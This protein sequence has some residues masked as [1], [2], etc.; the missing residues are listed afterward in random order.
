MDTKTLQV[1]L[2]VFVASLIRSTFG[3]GEGLLAVPLLALIIPTE[4]TA[5]VAVLLSITTAAM[6]V[7][8][9]WRKVHVS[10]TGWLHG[11]YIPGYSA[12]HFLVN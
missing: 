2:V 7:V 5:P 12:R 6:V 3:F 9:D 11:S 1:L 4:I 10:A 8:Q